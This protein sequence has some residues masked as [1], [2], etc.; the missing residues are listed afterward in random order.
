MSRPPMPRAMREDPPAGLTAEVHLDRVV[1]VGRVP[2]SATAGTVGPL[3][4]LSAGAATLGL[5]VMLALGPLAPPLIWQA[6]PNLTVNAVLLLVGAGLLAWAA[7]RQRRRRIR[8]EVGVHRIAVDEASMAWSE[9]RTVRPHE[10]GITLL[11]EDGR[12]LRIPPL[13]ERAEIWL[14]DTIADRVST[15]AAAIADP[16]A[17]AA[18]EALRGQLDR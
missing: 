2:R 18:L 9:V 1:L 14:V 10:R 4:A 17:R 16:D 8:L 3:I 13:P 11:A 7:L 12:A 5:G 15:A 6:W